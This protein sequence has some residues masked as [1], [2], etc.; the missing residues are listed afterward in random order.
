MPRHS[1]K[2]NDDDVLP[3]LQVRNAVHRRPRPQL[4]RDRAPPTIL[5]NDKRSS[6]RARRLKHRCAAESV[7]PGRWSARILSRAPPKLFAPFVK[8]GVG[9]CLCI[10]EVI[11]FIFSCLRSPQQF[12]ITGS[13]PPRIML[14]SRAMS[15]LNI[16]LRSR[17]EHDLLL[18]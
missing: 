2:P 7:Y 4:V 6:D 12:S 17:F 13:M 9:S 10:S 5:R 11:R 15:S 14:S 8:R 16:G 18:L 3:A 1:H